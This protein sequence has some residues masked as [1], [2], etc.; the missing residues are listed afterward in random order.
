M[1]VQ[2]NCQGLPGHCFCINAIFA[3]KT[4]LVGVGGKY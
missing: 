1:E 3:D 4:W 2:I